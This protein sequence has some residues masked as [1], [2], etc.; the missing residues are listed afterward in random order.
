V[1]KSEDRNLFRSH[2]LVL[3]DYLRAGLEMR[4]LQGSVICV[5]ANRHRGES[6]RQHRVSILEDSMN[7]ISGL[8]S[9]IEMF[10]L[11]ACRFHQYHILD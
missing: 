9:F 7:Q 11:M 5:A 10:V 6:Q 8:F 3:G 2:A 1:S 4:C